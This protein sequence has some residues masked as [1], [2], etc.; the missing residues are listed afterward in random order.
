MSCCFA[1]TSFKN[2]CLYN[3]AQDQVIHKYQ[4]IDASYQSNYSV[5]SS[6]VALLFKQNY[7]TGRRNTN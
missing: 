6:T 4:K 3:L 7:Y 1:M 2:D 5:A